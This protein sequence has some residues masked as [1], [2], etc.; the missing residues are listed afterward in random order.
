M[1]FAL[2]PPCAR[3]VR[4]VRV[5]S[6]RRR[7]LPWGFFGRGDTCAS[8]SGRRPPSNPG[9]SA[10]VGFVEALT[11]RRGS[12]DAR[13]PPRRSPDPYP[14][15]R[16]L[17]PRTPP[18]PRARRERGGVR[19][20]PAR[21]APHRRLGGRAGQRDPVRRD[22]AAQLPGQ[23]WAHLAAAHGSAVLALLVAV[24][25]R[26]KFQ[27]PAVPDRVPGA[28]DGG[29]YLRRL[30][31][32]DR[33]RDS[34]QPLLRPVLV[35][36]PDPTRDRG[37][38]TRAAPSTGGRAYRAGLVCVASAAGIGAVATAFVDP[39]LVAVSLFM[40]VVAV[41]TLAFQLYK[42]W[43][44]ENNDPGRDG[45]PPRLPGGAR[46]R[47]PR[48]PRYGGDRARLR[49]AVS[50]PGAG[51]P[52]PGGHRRAQQADRPQRGG[53]DAQG[54][55]RP[56]RVG[57]GGRRRGP[58]PSG[59]AED[60]GLPVA[61]GRSGHRAVRRAA[62][63]LQ[64]RP[65][66]PA[67]GTGLAG[68]GAPLVAGEHQRLVAGRQRGRL[69]PGFPVLPGVRGAD[70]TPG[71]GAGAVPQ[72]AHRGRAARH[73]PPRA[74][75]ARRRPRRRPARPVRPYLPGE[76]TAARLRRSGAWLLP[77][78]G[79]AVGGRGLGAGPVPVGP[80]QLGQDHPPG[81]APAAG[82][83]RGAQAADGGGARMTLTWAPE[84]TDI[85][86]GLRLRRQF[87]I[88]TREWLQRH[89]SSIAVLLL[90]LV[91]VGAVHAI[92]SSTFPDYVDDPGTYLSQAW[93]LQ[94]EHALSPYTYFYDHATAGWIQIALWSMLTNGFNRYDSAIAFGNEC[95]LI[96]K[97]VSAALVYALGRRLGFSRP[98]ATAA[99]LLF[100][101]CP[102][103]LVYTRWTFLD[104]LVTPWLLLAFVLAYSPR[105]TIWAGTA[106]ALSFATAT[107]T[108]ETTLVTL[109]AFAWAMAQNL[110]RRNRAQVI[111]V[112]AGSGVL[113]MG[114]YPVFAI[115]KGELFEGPGHNSVL[116]TAKWQLAGLDSSGSL[117][118]PAS[119]TRH[120][121]E[122]W[123]GYDRYL[124]LLGLAAIP[125]ALAVRR[126]RPVTLA[127]AIE[128]LLMVRGG[129][130][131][132]GA[133]AADR[134]PVGGGQHPRDRVLVVHDAI[135]TD[136]VH[137]Y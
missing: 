18:L 135:W 118:D 21:P 30:L 66:Y 54:A 115:Y 125:L 109:P 42:W 69:R 103:A 65:A 89:R 75:P 17:A 3:A 73:A 90:A 23:P 123:L 98:G 57:R 122:R 86:E 104:N 16:P 68:P 25:G 80:R 110:D 100:G 70:G 19:P 2:V 36:L 24:P 108:K 124:I 8:D 46:R 6:P 26:P 119:P 52:V 63:E 58:V 14:P 95:M 94:Y 132:A 82:P 106:A 77:V 127:L 38:P 72:V 93:S 131:T 133:G 59:S 64:R 126:L 117:L 114:L 121:F 99:T 34:G 44:P 113:L 9:R 128:W 33:H 22:P 84:V 88:A 20:D 105:R 55:G 41:T 85:R 130:G 45:E 29:R 7:G 56:V 81:S 4:A 79:D 10:V 112:S 71:A 60:G 28:R 12:S 47:P 62:D 13:T 129:D 97:V 53:R 5:V 91:T 102:L 101:L 78:P 37:R 50:G 61:P 39:F 136:L 137:H 96:A 111:A 67:P 15:I 51:L 1:T 76:G 107:L 49:A 120:L 43:S 74:Q 27:R 83:G 48:R 32:P 11:I 92:G 31:G 116:G 35:V 87:V 134:H 40:L